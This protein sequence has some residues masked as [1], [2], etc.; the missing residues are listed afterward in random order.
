MSAPYYQVCYEN[1]SMTDILPHAQDELI[2][3]IN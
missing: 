1:V 3:K 2:C